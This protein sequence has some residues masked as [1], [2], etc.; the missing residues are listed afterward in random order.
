MQKKILLVEDD[1]DIREIYVEMLT[2]EGYVVDQAV[3]GEIALQLVDSRAYDL[4]I[5]DIMLPKVNG[6]NVLKHIRR[7]ESKAL[8]T[9]V[10]MAS[11]LG[12]E[13]LIKD[14]LRLGVEGYIVKAH[15]DLSTMLEEV[16]KALKLA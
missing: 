7:P 4:I 3:D 1:F 15:T 11:N 12:H 6:L 13:Y 9:P 16:K 5:L 2:D 14:A 8:H 10:L